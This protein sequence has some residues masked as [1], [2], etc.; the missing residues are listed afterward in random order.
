MNGSQQA[1]PISKDNFHFMHLTNS[2]LKIEKNPNEQRIQFWQHL[3]VNHNF[4]VKKITY[5]PAI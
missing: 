1:V 4:P 5:C 3:F 2:G